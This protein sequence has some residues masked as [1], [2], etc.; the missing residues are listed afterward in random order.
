MKFLIFILF[1]FHFPGKYMNKLIKNYEV[2]E[3]II[4]KIIINV[5][6]NVVNDK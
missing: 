4:N 3:D 5:I 2:S 6:L 1:S